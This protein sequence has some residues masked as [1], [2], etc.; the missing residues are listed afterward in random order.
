MFKHLTEGKRDTPE[1]KQAIRYV[2]DDLTGRVWE[3]ST[4][5][6]GCRVVQKL[7]EMCSK[8]DRALLIDELKEKVWSATEHK[9]A[10]LVLLKVIEMVPREDRT[11][12]VEAYK[13]RGCELAQGRAGCRIFSRII[14]QDHESLPNDDQT[15]ALI[16]EVVECAPLMCCHRNAHHVMNS[17]LQYGQPYQK[18]WIAGVL[19]EQ[20]MDMSTDRYGSYVVVAA[21][22][23]CSRYDKALFRA[24]LRDPEHIKH[25]AASKCWHV[26]ATLAR[27]EH[28]ASVQNEEEQDRTINDIG[29]QEEDEEEEDDEEASARGQGKQ[30]EESKRATEVSEHGGK[31]TWTCRHYCSSVGSGGS[32]AAEV[33][34]DGSENVDA[35][36]PSQMSWLSG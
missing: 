13:T 9:H 34:T 3:A 5:E 23:H 31:G 17:I 8:K 26:V 35:L 14:E 6:H 16:S 22:N 1:E 10:N 32:S 20:V 12:I 19:R 28:E 2:L 11:F 25:M 18:E 33:D 30:A 29:A 15:D 24:L 27:G 21:L 7:L 36:S 4:H